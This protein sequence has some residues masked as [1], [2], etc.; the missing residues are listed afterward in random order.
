VGQCFAAITYGF[1]N[2]GAFVKL[3]VYAIG[4]VMI[5]DLIVSFFRS[6]LFF[7][8]V[9][10]MLLV[11]VV[12]W[13]ELV[14]SGYWLR[15]FLDGT[16]SSLEGSDQAPDVPDFDLK[17]LF[18]TGLKGMG[19]ALVYVMPIVTI[20]L[21]PLGLLA[22]ADSD[23][24]RAFD[25]V[26]AVRE[27]GR[28]PGPLLRVWPAM[29]LWGGLMVVVDVLLTIATFTLAGL[30]VTN[31][32]GILGSFVLIAVGGA[33]IAAVTAMFMTVVFR[34]VGMLGRFHPEY[35][36]AL[37][38]APGAGRVAGSFAFAVAC[39]LALFL[40]VIPRVLPPMAPV[41]D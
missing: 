32:W 36:D 30:S 12:L 35:L 27:A 14:I 11:L 26:W 7:T 39:V 2:L 22:L 37:P 3:V 29:L 28:R 8:A 25:L 31:G 10:Q 13:G 34:C 15:F 4:L 40:V 18:R 23:D 20:P 1:S 16:I 24:S 41:A 21:L 6:F 9:G 19:M 38:E 5:V 17:E 33:I